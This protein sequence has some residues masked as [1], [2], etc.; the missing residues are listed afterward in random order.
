M[1]V[2]SSKSRSPTKELDVSLTAFCCLQLGHF[3]LLTERQKL[4]IQN[5]IFLAATGSQNPIGKH[6]WKQ[7]A[8]HQVQA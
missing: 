3:L 1:S 2:P 8:V 7:N 5:M 4:C 6:Y